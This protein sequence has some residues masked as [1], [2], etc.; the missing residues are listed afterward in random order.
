[1]SVKTSEQ[2]FAALS[3]GTKW[4]AGVAF[5]RTNGLPLDDKSIFRRYPR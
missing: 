3:A 2:L 5:N 1:M 4:D